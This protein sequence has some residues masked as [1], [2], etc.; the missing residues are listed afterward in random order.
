MSV[1]DCIT[2]LS[3]FSFPTLLSNSKLRQV[4]SSLSVFK[5]F[6]E[7][8]VVNI[9]IVDPRIANCKNI[10]FPI[11]VFGYKNLTRFQSAIAFAFPARLISET[12]F[13]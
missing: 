8:V 7:P 11:S 10:T 13:I 3:T 1:P 9:F 5:A 4:L 2:W 12:S 6:R